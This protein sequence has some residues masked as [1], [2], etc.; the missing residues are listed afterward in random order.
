MA[1]TT[2]N[3][4]A[5]NTVYNVACGGETVLNDLILKLRDLL[6][7]FDPK[8]SS[9]ELSYGSERKGDVRYSLASIEKA[10][11]HLGYKPTHDINKGLEE[12]IEWYWKYFKS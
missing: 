6:S 3:S 1:A 11:R 8:V 5:L 10:N 12:A 9:V 7:K 4:D 2:T